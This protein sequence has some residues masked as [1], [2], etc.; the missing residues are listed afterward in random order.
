MVSD[1]MI[2]IEIASGYLES[3]HNAVNMY[4][5]PLFDYI[6]G[7]SKSIASFEN[8]SEMIGTSGKGSFSLATPQPAGM[9]RMILQILLF[10]L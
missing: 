2:E 6:K 7:P 8:T 4:L 3:T 5:F 10:L 1:N 9:D